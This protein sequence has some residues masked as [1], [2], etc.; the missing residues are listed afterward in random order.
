MLKVIF[1]PSGNTAAFKDGRQ[2]PDLQDSWFMIYVQ[3]LVAV[4]IDPTEV[5]FAMPDA[6]R[7][8]VFET[9]SG[10][11]NWRIGA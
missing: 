6:R 7:A 5:E 4:G 10:S 9:E 11:Y 1:F 8:T 2:V 3:L